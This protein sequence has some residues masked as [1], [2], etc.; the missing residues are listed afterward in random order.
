MIWSRTIFRLS[1]LALLA[2]KFD[3]FEPANLTFY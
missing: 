3:Y 1:H 2:L